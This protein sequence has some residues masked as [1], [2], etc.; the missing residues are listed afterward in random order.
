MSS[1]NQSPQYQKA[2][3]MYL[4]AQTNEEKLKW[5][6]EMMRECPKHKSAEKM[7]ANLKTRY[8]KLKEKIE[9][10]KKTSKGAKKAGIKKEDL[11][12]VI[13]GMTNSGKSTLISRLTNALP[14]IS[15]YFFTTKIPVI[16]IMKHSGINIQLIEI[17]A[18]S[19]EYYDRGT[20]NSADVILI[21]VENL[22]QIENIKE[23]LSKSAG[24]N[25]VV[26]NKIDFLNENEKRKTEATLKSRKYNF[27]MIS[28]KTGEGIEELK[29]KIFGSF[30]KL[31]IYT[32]EPGKP[33]SEK[34]FIMEDN[35]SVNDIALKIFR[36]S[37]KIKETKIW[38][39]SSK[40]PGQQVGLK[41]KLKDL[42]I[43]EFKTN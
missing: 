41:H 40:F 12:A 16:G 34:P 33:K 31:R 11:Q 1:T 24:K 8:I 35:S 2:A 19:S 3:G 26:F 14:E 9:T 43:V 22:N 42:D 32:K 29:D 23:N 5:L 6:E 27:V 20:V 25:I 10:I 15:P 36:N 28:A 39:P 18:I 37:S 13:V 7:L 38:G 21:L 4:R 30:G 17:P